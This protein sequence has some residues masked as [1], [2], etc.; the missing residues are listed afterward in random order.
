MFL[1]FNLLRYY[2]TLWIWTVGI[3]INIYCYQ[4]IRIADKNFRRSK[5][6]E[7]WLIDENDNRLKLRPTK[8]SRKD[9]VKWKNPDKIILK[10]FK[11]FICF[12][13]AIGT[14]WT[15]LLKVHTE[16]SQ[17][18]NMF[19]WDLNKPQLVRVNNDSSPFLLLFWKLFF[20]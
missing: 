15:S 7:F 18:S 19:D 4:K 17:I 13:S 1:I 2:N 3:E 16:P 11:G 10:Y 8:Y 12:I 5:R 9:K 20:R 14:V 6:K